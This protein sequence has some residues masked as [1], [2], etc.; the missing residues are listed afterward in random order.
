MLNFY[1]IQNYQIQMILKLNGDIMPDN[2]C[3]RCKGRFWWYNT[4]DYCNKCEDDIKKEWML[5]GDKLSNI[6]DQEGR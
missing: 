4:R 5:E 3:L 1:Y 6:K 2:Y